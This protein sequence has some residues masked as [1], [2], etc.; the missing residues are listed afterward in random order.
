MERDSPCS[1]LCPHLPLLSLPVLSHASFSRSS[2]NR[3]NPTSLVSVQCLVIRLP[4]HREPLICPPRLPQHRSP[5]DAPGSF[6]W[7][8]KTHQQQGGFQQCDPGRTVSL[9]C[10][11]SETPP[12]YTAKKL[13]E[14]LIHNLQGQ[15]HFG[16]FSPKT[17]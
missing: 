9:T 16:Y 6:I 3:Q 17:H 14:A 8:A 10:L 2:Q 15:N 7:E 11:A 12:L 13:T 4:V 5:L 1:I